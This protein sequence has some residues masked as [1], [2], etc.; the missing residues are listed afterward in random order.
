MKLRFD[1]VRDLLENAD[2]YYEAYHRAETFSGPSLYFH[3]RALDTRHAPAS[4]Q[5]LEYVYATLASWGMHRMGLGGSK[6]C[7]FTDFRVSVERLE[8]KIRHAQTIAPGTLD[9]AGWANLKEIFI[10]VRIMASKTL[11]VG[12][13]KVMHHMMPNIIPPIDREYTLRYVCGRT[14][15]VNDTEKEWQTMRSM[16]EGFFVPVA[17]DTAFAAKADCWIA[18]RRP[19]DTSVMKIVDNLLI[20]SRKST[21]A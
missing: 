20:G 9:E 4:P 10:G 15:F 18:A 14:M 8:D 3:K 16:I 11:L 5:H 6:M 21:L 12:N 17:I 1:R 19:W 2:R 7:G 13:S